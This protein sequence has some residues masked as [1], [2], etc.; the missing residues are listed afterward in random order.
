MEK[1]EINHHGGFTPFFA[2]QNL[3]RH[4]FGVLYYMCK[5]NQDIKMIAFVISEYSYCDYN[6]K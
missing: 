1:R 6:V 5:S 2:A 3:H 4:Y